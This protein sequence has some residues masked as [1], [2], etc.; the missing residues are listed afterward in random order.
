MSHRLV[1]A[2]LVSIGLHA[3]LLLVRCGAP[4]PVAEELS[5]TLVDLQS[6]EPPV[7]VE[8]PT[9]AA[10]PPPPPP[11]P[12]VSA[13]PPP[14]DVAPD[15]PTET[16][17]PPEPQVPVPT[18]PAPASAVESA[19]SDPAS[20]T[21]ATTAARNGTG[22]SEAAP[23]GAE[24]LDNRDFKPFGNQK[25]AYPEVARRMGVEGSATLRILVNVRGQ[26]EKIEVEK[27]SGHSSF[28]SAAVATAEKWRFAPPRQKG[29]PVPVWYTRTIAFR[30]HE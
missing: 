24:T 19:A 8:A 16:V 30:L 1:L 4:A 13:I 6:E 29:R 17:R 22:N 18:P 20:T 15:A 10:S 28:G 11:P 21:M 25:P 3:G 5:E 27:W 2:L 26:V 23:V 12:V 7:P 9:Q 14:E